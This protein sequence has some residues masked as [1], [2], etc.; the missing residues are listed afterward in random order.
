MIQY[1]MTMLCCTIMFQFLIPYHNNVLCHYSDLLSHNN[2]PLSLFSGLFLITMIHCLKT[3]IHYLTT[4]VHFPITMFLCIIKI[5]HCLF[6]VAYCPFT[7]VL[8]ISQWSTV[9]SSITVA[10]C[11]TILLQWPTASLQDLEA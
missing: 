11:P 7:M 3:I 1:P 2:S 10:Y 4:V 6:T 8:T 5:F 9:L